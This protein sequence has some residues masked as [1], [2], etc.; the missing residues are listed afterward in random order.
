MDSFLQQPFGH[1]IFVVL[2]NMYSDV[3]RVSTPSGYIVYDMEP[4]TPD[5][6]SSLR[7]VVEMS[8]GH[9]VSVFI[10][11]SA[12]MKTIWGLSGKRKL[13]VEDRISGGHSNADSLGVSLYKTES[14]CLRQRCHLPKC[15]A[16]NYQQNGTCQLLPRTGG[17]CD[18]P[19]ELEGSSFVYLTGCNGEVLGKLTTV[20]W[21]PVTSA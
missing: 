10:I 3:V 15:S 1:S 21:M 6:I 14:G 2:K 12:A 5:M 19:G 11:L 16:Y 7:W 9:F 18:T 8:F 13:C 17:A 4:A 20:E